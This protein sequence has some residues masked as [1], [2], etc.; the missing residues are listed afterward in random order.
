MD[1]FN[2]FIYIVINFDDFVVP[3]DGPLHCTSESLFHCRQGS[4]E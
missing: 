2:T 4:S 1:L 3:D